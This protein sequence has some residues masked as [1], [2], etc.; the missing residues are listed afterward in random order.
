MQFAKGR[1]KG[2]ILVAENH[3]KGEPLKHFEDYFSHA[4][5]TDD[6][7]K[8]F[9]LSQSVQLPGSNEAT[10]AQ[11]SND[12]LILNA[13]NQKGDSKSRIVALS[14]NGGKT[15][16]SVFI[17]KNL[18]DPVCEGSILNIGKKSGK[19]I[20][21]F[22]NAADTMFRNNL[23]LRISFDE[24]TTWPLSFLVDKSPEGKKGKR[25]HSL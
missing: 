22:C 17:D 8:T 9:K 20:L 10:A 1:H 14:R 21:A 18:P 4:Y 3:S 16:D 13:R 2:R 5:Y 19:N 12:G 6:H 25:L 11:I 24:G 7:G 15:F 23:T